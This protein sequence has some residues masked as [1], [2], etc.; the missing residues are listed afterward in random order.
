M[1]NPDLTSTPSPRVA[2]AA[3]GERAPRLHNKDW[4]RHVRQ[5]DALSRTPG[6]QALRDRILV[7]AAPGPGERAL[8][9]GAGTGL[10]TLALSDRCAGVWAIDISPAMVEHLR[11][12]VAGRN[13]M[14]VY[15]LV[16]SADSLPLEDV[17]VDLI[18]SN[19]CFHH[20]DE[21]GKRQAIAEAF[22]ILKPAGRLVFADMMFGWSLADGRN[23]EVIS[24]KLRAMARRGPAGYARIARNALRALTGAGE[25]PATPQWWRRELLAAGF[26]DVSVECLEHEGGIAAAVKP[27]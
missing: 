6:F 7:R 5:A 17:A 10:L 24:A 16:G 14:N 23:R 26:S 12:L 21:D 9:V 20:L 3:P 1:A 8:D 15:P 18:V 27:P 4:D 22:R 11:W 19:Y 25:H 13:L 2:G